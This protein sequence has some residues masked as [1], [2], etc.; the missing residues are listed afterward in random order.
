MNTAPI[1][2]KVRSFCT[3]LRDDWVMMGAY[4][5]CDIYEGWAKNQPEVWYSPQGGGMNVTVGTDMNIAVRV[6]DVTG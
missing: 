1:I 4:V 5:K 3:T 2:P 6:G